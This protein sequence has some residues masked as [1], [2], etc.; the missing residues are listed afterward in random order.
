MQ[1]P[2]DRLQRPIK[3]QTVADLEETGQ[4]IHDSESFRNVINSDSQRV[5]IFIDHMAWI[6]RMIPR[7]GSKP[8][9]DDMFDALQETI[10]SAF[11]L[12]DTI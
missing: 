1:I 10:Q 12:S 2:M 9:F 11:R 4:S 7:V 5:A 6:L 3:A 8:S